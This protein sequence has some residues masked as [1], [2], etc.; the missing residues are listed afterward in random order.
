MSRLRRQLDAEHF[1]RLDDR[2]RCKQRGRLRH[3][4]LSN[5]PAQVTLPGGFIPERIEDGERG[6]SE[7]QREPHEGGRLL[8]R[9]YKPLAQEVGDLFRLAWFGFETS[10]QCKLHNASPC[11]RRLPREAASEAED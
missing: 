6:G 3:Q 4:G 2:R 5:R 7:P 8:I 1:E 11:I 9:E 10:E